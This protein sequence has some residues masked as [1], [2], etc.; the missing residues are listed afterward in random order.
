[1]PKLN[2]WQFFLYHRISSTSVFSDEKLNEI[3]RELIS[4]KDSL[5]FC[6]SMHHPKN[7]Q[8]REYAIKNE[9]ENYYWNFEYI[10]DYIRKLVLEKRKQI[11]S[12]SSIYCYTIIKP[13]NI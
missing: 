1:M 10:F 8:K 9:T 12:D 3:C 7:I 5:L 6:F 13:K 4:W 11:V 2:T